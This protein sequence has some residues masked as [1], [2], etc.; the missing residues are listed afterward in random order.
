MNGRLAMIGTIGLIWFADAG[1]EENPPVLDTPTPRKSASAFYP[2]EVLARTRDN[3]TNQPWGQI[4]RDSIVAA[5]QPWLQM[6]DEMLWDLMFS[7]SIKRSWMVWSDGHCPMC[8]QPVPMYEWTI[9]ALGSSVES[10]VSTLW[11][12]FSQE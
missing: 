2:A 4:A 8:Q 7:N 12:V 11:R 9:D 6:S 10:A 1:A 3:A 5:A